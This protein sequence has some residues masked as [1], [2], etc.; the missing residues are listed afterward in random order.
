MHQILDEG[1]DIAR[2]TEKLPANLVE[3]FVPF[4]KL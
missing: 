1:T 3:Q 2:T 4:E